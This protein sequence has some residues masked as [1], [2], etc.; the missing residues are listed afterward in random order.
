VGQRQLQNDIERL[1]RAA[2]V[3][4]AQPDHLGRECLDVDVLA[5][6]PLLELIDPTLQCCNVVRHGASVRNDACVCS[7]SSRA[8]RT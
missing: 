8:R 1:C 4:A 7:A 2:E 3:P 5:L 6:E